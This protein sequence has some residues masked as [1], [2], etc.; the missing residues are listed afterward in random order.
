[1]TG[2]NRRLN[3]ERKRTTFVLF[4]TFLL[5]NRFHSFSLQIKFYFLRGGHSIKNFM[6]SKNMCSLNHFKASF[7]S[8][9][10]TNS[11]GAKITN[12]SP[13]VYEVE[14]SKFHIQTVIFLFNFEHWIRKRLSTTAIESEVTK[15][16]PPIFANF[17]QVFL[18]ILSQYFHMT[19]PVRC[20][21]SKLCVQVSEIPFNCWENQN[22]FDSGGKSLKNCARISR[23]RIELTFFERNSSNKILN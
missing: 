21:S 5:V 22:Y 6:A 20:S 12:L 4:L 15:I 9:N 19:S 7:R 10:R 13:I 11:R 2:L 1:M 18:E 16:P 14:F 3:F 17:P 23:L 8:K